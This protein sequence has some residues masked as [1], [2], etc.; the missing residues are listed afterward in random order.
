LRRTAQIGILNNKL[1]FVTITEKLLGS[2]T[3]FKAWI[4]AKKAA[5]SKL[6][7]YVYHQYIYA[8]VSGKGKL[9]YLRYALR[10]D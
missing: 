4:A 9:D 8:M 2:M 7:E 1:K 6:E 3:E 5:A 10:T